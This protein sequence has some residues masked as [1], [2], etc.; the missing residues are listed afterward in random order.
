MQHF[1]PN[2]KLPQNVDFGA[3]CHNKMVDSPDIK[4]KK[5][6][7]PSVLNVF[8]FQAPDK[9]AKQKTLEEIEL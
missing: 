7:K 9:Q 2:S 6:K 1:S 4:H 3:F 5:Q 8:S